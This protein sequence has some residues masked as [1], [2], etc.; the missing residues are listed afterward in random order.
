[1]KNS[2]E[3]KKVYKPAEFE[4]VSVDQSDIICTSGGSSIMS[5]EMDDDL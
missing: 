4:I 3:E 2:E 5:L 1:M